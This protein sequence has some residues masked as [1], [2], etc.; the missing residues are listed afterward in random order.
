MYSWFRGMFL[1]GEDLAPCILF[2]LASIKKPV[3]C[4]LVELSA[5]CS[6]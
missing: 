5:E 1:L 3:M 2:K 4:V 6:G